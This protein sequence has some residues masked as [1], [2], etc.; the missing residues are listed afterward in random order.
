MC[1]RDSSFIVRAV[2]EAPPGS[3]FVIGTEVNLVNR[4]DTE[5]PDK[6]VIP[7]RRSLCPNMFRITARHLLYVLEQLVAGKPVEVVRLPEETIRWARVALERM[8]KL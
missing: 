7:L 3:S 5:H 1:I 8:L 4:L 2:E 6:Q